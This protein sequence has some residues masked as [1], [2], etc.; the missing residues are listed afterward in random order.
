MHIP[1]LLSETIAALAPRPGGVY[2]DGTLGGG[3]HAEEILRRSSPDGVLLG[4]DRDAEAVGRCRARLAPFGARFVAVHA[5][6]SEMAAAVREAGVRSPDGILLDLGVSSFQLDDPARGFSFRADGPLDM[7]MDTS[8][9]RTAAELIDSFTGDPEG[10]AGIFREYGEEPRAMRVARA[11]LLAR[12]RGPFSGT[13]HLAEVV[14]R[15]LGGRRGAARHPATRV[16]QALRIAVN[17]EFGQLSAALEA[18]LSLLAPAG[19]LAVISFHSL[20]DRIVKLALR[21]HELRR[22]ALEQG[23]F[24][25]EGAQPRVERVLRRAVSPSEA[26]VAANPRSRSAKLR[27]VRR[28][29]C[30]A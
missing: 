3:G 14:E 15:A 21:R 20:E 23:G 26:E 27:A 10:L 29:A 8:R 19:V 30:A 6:F 5:P 2:L 28:L 24:R 4:L 1:V 22:V 13:A 11:V 25:A 9:G 17:D 7:R 12:E 18:A 16:F